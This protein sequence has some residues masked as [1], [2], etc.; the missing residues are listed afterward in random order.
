M[1]TLF[2]IC[3]LPGSGKT[4]LA[5]RLER[6]RPALR[7]TPDEWMARIVGDGNDGVKR[8]AVEK[9][10]WEIAQR[11][12]SLGV[13]AILESGFWARSERDEFRAQAAALGADTKLY[14]LDVPL[15]ELKRRL[16]LRNAVLPPDTFHVNVADLDSWASGFEPPTLEEL[17]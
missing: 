9:V 8:A 6:E 12:L 5:K 11:V 14:Y 1:P 15:D 17:E 16:T 3:G 4:T 13:D 7:L 10:Q 2:L